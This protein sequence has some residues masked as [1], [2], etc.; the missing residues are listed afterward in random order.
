MHMPSGLPIRLKALQSSQLEVCT[1]ARR[2]M[3]G[4]TVGLDLQKAS[5]LD[6]AGRRLYAPLP[7]LSLH[8]RHTQSSPAVKLFAANSK[9]GETIGLRMWAVL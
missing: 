5:C 7:R 9:D 8:A 1:G 3:A 2:Y 6:S 4:C